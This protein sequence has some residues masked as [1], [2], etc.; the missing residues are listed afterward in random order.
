MTKQS[1]LEE[2]VDVGKFLVKPRTIVLLLI[3]WALYA[4]GCANV[5]NTNYERQLPEPVQ[6]ERTVMSAEEEMERLRHPRYSRP[7]EEKKP[8]EIDID[9]DEPGP[10]I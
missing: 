3:G 7:V 6:M 5:E 10:E 8:Y 2:I 4:A 1:L 9:F